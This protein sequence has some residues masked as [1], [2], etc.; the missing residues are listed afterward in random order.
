MNK[1][2]HGSLIAELH[3]IYK[4]VVQSKKTLLKTTIIIT[5]RYT[6]GKRRESEKGKD[7]KGHL[8]KEGRQFIG[9]WYY[10]TITLG[11]GRRVKGIHLKRKIEQ[12]RS[13]ADKLHIIIH[14]CL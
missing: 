13:M 14:N 1:K 5:L 4:V 3:G 2:P 11:E 12:L 8:E 7:W 10:N 9:V 6:L